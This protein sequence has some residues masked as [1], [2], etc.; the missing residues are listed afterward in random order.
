MTE[1]AVTDCSNETTD[2]ICADCAGACDDE[3]EL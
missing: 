1:C 2:Y 3:S